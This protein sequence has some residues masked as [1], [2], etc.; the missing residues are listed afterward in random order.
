MIR[1]LWPLWKTG[2]E[3]TGKHLSERTIEIQLWMKGHGWKMRKPSP[4]IE[5]SSLNSAL[6]P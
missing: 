6:H 4:S 5:Q 1:K 2:R 3:V